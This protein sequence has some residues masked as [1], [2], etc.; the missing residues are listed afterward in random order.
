V[1]GAILVATVV[2]TI[3]GLVMAGPHV[4]EALTA[5]SFQSEPSLEGVGAAIWHGL[6]I[7]TFNPFYWVFIGLLTALQLVWPARRDEARPGVEMAVD[8][9]WFVVNNALQFTIVA[10]TLGAVTVAYT[11]IL[12]SWSLNLQQ[13]IGRVGLIVVAYV[14]TDALAYA[15]HVC[16][17]KV[18]TLW[19]FHTVHHSQQRLNALSDNRTHMGETIAAALIIFV[20]S[21]VLGLNATAA[22]TIAFIGLFYAAMLHSNIR[23]N[24]GPLRFVLLGPQPHRVHHSVSPEHFEHN[25]GTTFPWWDMLFGTYWWDTTVYPSTGVTDRTFPLRQTHDLSPLKWFVVFV[26][27]FVYPFQA[28]YKSWRHIDRDGDAA[29]SVTP[30][31]AVT[32]E[33]SVP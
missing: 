5:Q 28:I 29:D 9:V 12:G 8:I 20:P 19:R 13:Y 11:E 21:Q 6:E 4:T 1:V 14:L 31:Q 17:H 26:R 32:S 27:Q 22:S 2:G 30:A 15:T 18:P 33:P 7:S 3:V 23:T 16:H 25:F 10:V 24:L